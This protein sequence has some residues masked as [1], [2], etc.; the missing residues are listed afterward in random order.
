MLSSAAWD[1]VIRTVRTAQRRLFPMT[2]LLK[3]TID[4]FRHRLLATS[5]NIRPS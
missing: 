1:E 2:S 5:P 4:H 3:L